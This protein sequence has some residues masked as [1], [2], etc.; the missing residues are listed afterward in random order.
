M[1][2]PFEWQK[3]PNL[4]YCDY[5]EHLFLHI[6]ICENPAPDSKE[7]VDCGGI[8]AFT[9]PELNDLYSGF[10]AKQEWRRNCFDIIKN[11]KEVYLILLNRFMDSCPYPKDCLFESYNEKFGSWSKEKNQKLFEEIK[12][13]KIRS[14]KK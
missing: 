7:V 10:E 5:L 6:L 8:I 9:V 14:A 2:H 11:D 4:V 12:K 3:A 1:K 13:F